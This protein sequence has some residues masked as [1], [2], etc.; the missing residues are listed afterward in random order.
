MY[1]KHIVFFGFGRFQK[2]SNLRENRIA[3][4]VKSGFQITVIKLVMFS[5]I[6]PITANRN[7]TVNSN[8]KHVTGIKCSQKEQ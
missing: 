1:F 5:H 3:I 8:Q 4:L 6:W 2:L 7:I